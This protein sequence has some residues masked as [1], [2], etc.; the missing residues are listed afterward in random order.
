MPA[1]G[2][3]V[4]VHLYSIAIKMTINTTRWASGVRPFYIL[5]IFAYTFC[6]SGCRQPEGTGAGVPVV[7]ARVLNNKTLQPQATPIVI[8]LDSL[9]NAVRTNPQIAV[10]DSIPYLC[11]YN[12]NRHSIDIY[13]TDHFNLFKRL[14]LPGSGPQAIRHCDGFLL[15]NSDSLFVVDTQES[16]LFRL[17]LQGQVLKVTDVQLN[18]DFLLSTEHFYPP[19]FNP[20]L[21]SIGLWCYYNTWPGNKEFYERA[22][23]IEINPTNGKPVDFFG[24]FPE[25]HKGDDICMIYNTINGLESN[26]FLYNYFAKDPVIY[27]YRLADHQLLSRKK[28]ASKW[29]SKKLP[30]LMQAGQ[31]PPGNEEMHH[32]VKQGGT[33]LRL[34]ANPEG[35]LLYRIVELEKDPLTTDDNFIPFAVLVLDRE[36]NILCEKKFAGRLYN[37][38]DIFALDNRLFV[39]RNNVLNPA[40]SEDKLLY[41][42][43][44]VTDNP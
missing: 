6:C 36:L 19:Y 35:T 25:S 10:L 9:S 30:P 3:A 12:A 27:T 17:N 44:A 23:N 40:F 13:Q 8:A 22:G 33:Y 4:H 42:V 2:R 43:F 11:F 15:H 34:L 1:N 41:E 32:Y 18:D 20:H 5:I 21:A 16:R 39:S 29:L 14:T 37:V 24:G 28:V 31:E 7:N 38:F 26:G